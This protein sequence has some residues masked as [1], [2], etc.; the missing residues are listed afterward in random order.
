MLFYNTGADIKEMQHS[1]YSQ[2][3]KGNFLNHWNQVAS[4]RK[5]VIAAVN[6][7]AVSDLVLVYCRIAFY[8]WLFVVFTD[9]K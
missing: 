5:P 8:L 1:N 4:C 7:F 9:K 3:I 6:G 2:N